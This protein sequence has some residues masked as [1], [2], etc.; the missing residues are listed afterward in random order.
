[1]GAA[2]ANVIDALRQSPA[3]LADRVYKI[4]G[5]YLVRPG[6]RAG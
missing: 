4:N 1:M 3:V 2:N 6:P 5:D